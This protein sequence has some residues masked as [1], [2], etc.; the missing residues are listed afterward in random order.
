VLGHSV[1]D[2]DRIR[3]GEAGLSGEEEYK[4][5]EYERYLERERRDADIWPRDEGYGTDHRTPSRPSVPRL[6]KCK[7]CGTEFFEIRWRER[8]PR[9][10][11]PAIK[12]SSSHGT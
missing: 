3:A 4:R 9:C 10:G 5:R 7:K 11:G 8:C 6:R 12:V 2:C 1:A